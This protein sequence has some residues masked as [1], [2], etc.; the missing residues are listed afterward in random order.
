VRSDFKPE[1]HGGEFW[2]HFVNIG[3]RAK[4][5]GADLVF[6]EGVL[7][8]G[9]GLRIYRDSG[10]YIVA[11]RLKEARTSPLKFIPDEHDVSHLPAWVRAPKQIG[12]GHLRKLATA[13]AALLATLDESIPGSYLIPK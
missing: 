13:N 10:S 2:K 9:P 1:D 11:A 3:E 4:A 6:E 5:W 7:T 12:D 8:Q